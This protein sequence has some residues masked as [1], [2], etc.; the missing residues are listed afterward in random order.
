VLFLLFTKLSITTFLCPFC[1]LSNDF[2][3]FQF[4]DFFLIEQFNQFRQQGYSI[5][6]GK[7][8]PALHVLLL[9]LKT[10]FAQSL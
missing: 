8:V 6:Y 4:A 1:R 5:S 2:G 9:P 7:G 10:I 3:G